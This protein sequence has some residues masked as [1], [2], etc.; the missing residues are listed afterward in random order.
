MPSPDVD[1]IEVVA[2]PPIVPLRVAVEP[3]QIEKLAPALAEGMG[4]TVRLIEETAAGQ[5]PTGSSVV[6]INM[7][8]PI[9]VSETS[10]V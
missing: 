6:T 1:Q 7:I 8:D 9:P 10:G 4:D 3:S 5:I 2:A